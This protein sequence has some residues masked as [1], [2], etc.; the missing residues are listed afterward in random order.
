VMGTLGKRIGMGLFGGG[1][2]VKGTRGRSPVICFVERVLY[3]SLPT[4]LSVSAMTDCRPTRFYW[5]VSRVSPGYSRPAIPLRSAAFPLVQ[6]PRLRPLGVREEILWELA[7][8][9]VFCVAP[10]FLQYDHFCF[11]HVIIPVR[12]AI[13]CPVFVSVHFIRVYIRFF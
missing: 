8:G 7:L 3:R 4:F 1:D 10:S 9:S 5:G 12:F 6:S 2:F 11:V 13:S